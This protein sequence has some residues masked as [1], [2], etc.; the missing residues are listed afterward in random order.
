MKRTAT[1]IEASIKMLSDSIEASKEL[2]LIYPNLFIVNYP[3]KQVKYRSNLTEK[4]FI[5]A[6]KNNEKYTK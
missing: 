6:I 4:E 1:E 2:E 5:K 3:N